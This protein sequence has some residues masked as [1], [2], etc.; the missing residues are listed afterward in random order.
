MSSIRFF[1]FFIRLVCCCVFI[2]L[3]STRM[4]VKFSYKINV[5]ICRVKPGAAT[6]FK[7]LCHNFSRDIPYCL[8]FNR[9]FS[10]VFVFAQFMLWLHLIN[11][12]HQT[13]HLLLFLFCF[14]HFHFFVCV[15][16]LCA[17]YV[18]TVLHFSYILSRQLSFIV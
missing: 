7:D 11:G 8:W 15:F 6:I 9:R 16:F 18:L 14:I 12:L 13:F 2:S 10:V 17:L 5:H 1:L 3:Q 4:N